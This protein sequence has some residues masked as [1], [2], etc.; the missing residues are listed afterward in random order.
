MISGAVAAILWPWGDKT[1]VWV[2]AGIIESTPDCFLWM[3]CYVR[4]MDHCYLGIL[5]L[6]VE[7]SLI[8]LEILFLGIYHKGHL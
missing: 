6:A 3:F 7:A 2:L 5:L 8:K 1:K 4:K